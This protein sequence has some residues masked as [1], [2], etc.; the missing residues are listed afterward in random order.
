MLKVR[1][2][3]GAAKDMPFTMLAR[4]THRAYLQDS[5]LFRRKEILD[6]LTKLPETAHLLCEF[7]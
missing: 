7:S 6:L 5:H 2:G 3:V 1:V 4:L